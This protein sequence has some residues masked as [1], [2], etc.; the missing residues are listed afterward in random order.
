MT[1]TISLELLKQTLH[2]NPET[3]IWT[4]LV[5]R[6]VYAAGTVTGSLDKDGYKV[7]V[8][9][10]KCFRSSRLAWFYMTGV[11]PTVEL[12]HK[13]TIRHHDW[14]DNLRLAT[15]S[16]NQA[17]RRVRS[18]NFLGVKG[19]FRSKARERP[20]AAKIMAGGIYRYLGRFSTIDEA[21][22]AYSKAAS[23]AFGEFART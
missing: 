16:Q 5:R 17:N 20:Y 12:D 18:N 9:N 10:G 2:Y 21:S 6:G 19:V 4:N 13:D 14:W 22:A 15:H 3:G 11:W 23:E 7:I 1:Q 8:I